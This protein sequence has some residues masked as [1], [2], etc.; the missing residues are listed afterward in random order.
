MADGKDCH[1][2]RA[3]G[4]ATQ[5]WLAVSD[6][7]GAKGDRPVPLPHAE[8]SCKQGFRASSAGFQPYDL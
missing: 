7:R 1:R 2:Q 6:E 3:E 5:V 4:V 8:S